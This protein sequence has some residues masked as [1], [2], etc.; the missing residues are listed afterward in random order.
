M[1][2]T[3]ESHR[4]AQRTGQLEQQHLYHRVPQGAFYSLLYLNEKFP[5][6]KSRLLYVV[7]TLES[8]RLAQRT[9]QLEQQHLYHPVPQ[10]CILQLALLK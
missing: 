9:G 4:L 2:W 1:V 6:D 8:C 5:H 7:W 3:L 10:E